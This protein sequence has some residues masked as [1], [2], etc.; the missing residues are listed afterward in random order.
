MIRI[1]YNASI[2]SWAKSN[3]TMR[4]GVFFVAKNI[5]NELLKREDVEVVCYC[6]ILR[7]FELNEYLSECYPSVKCITDTKSRKV[8]YL[9][10]KLSSIRTINCNKKIGKKIIGLIRR[11]FVY[12]INIL[13]HF[14]KKTP[15]H[16]YDVYLSPW[17]SVPCFIKKTNLPCFIIVHDMMPFIFPEYKGMLK[18]S[19]AFGRVIKDISP[20]LYYLAI[21]EA[22]KTDFIKYCPN[23][24]KDQIFVSYNGI[25][26]D[27]KRVSDSEIQLIRNKYLINE[28]YIF[29][30]GNILPHKNLI[31]QIQSFL[32]FT[33]RYDIQDLKYV[34]A[35]GNSNFSSLI[36]SKF[37]NDYGKRILYIGYVDDV[38]LPSLYSGAHWFS[39]TSKYEGFGLPVLEAM[40][41]GCPVVTSSCSSLPEISGNAAIIVNC[42]DKEQHVQAFYKYYFD[43]E[44]R[45]NKINEGYDWSRKFSWQKSVADK[46]NIITAIISKEN[47]E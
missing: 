5:L 7:Y 36:K 42:D 38:D 16:D 1:L 30:L 24:N 45:L 8:L 26:D 12:G 17:N 34:I 40:R 46:I 37:P 15:I 21:S 23:V 6:D 11:L 25:P 10:K 18:P 44:F 2:I 28:K 3:S 13:Q 27:F 39:F 35:G 4:S 41:C 19:N 31:M 9:S 47:R 32:E 22:T 29:S 20:K 33:D 14:C 43:E